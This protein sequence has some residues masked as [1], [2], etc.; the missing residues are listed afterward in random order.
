MVNKVL[1]CNSAGSRRLRLRS[2]RGQYSAA[3]VARPF[4]RKFPYLGEIDR[5]SNLD[6]SNYNGLQVT[7]TQRPSHGLSFLAGYTYSHAFDDSS[8]NDNDNQLP[9]DSHHPTARSL[10]E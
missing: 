8:N 4:F 10:R 7:L 5:L 3:Q 2:Q 1:S 9:P 6:K